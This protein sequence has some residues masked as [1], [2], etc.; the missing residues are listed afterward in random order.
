MRIDD[1]DPPREQPGAAASILTTLEACGFEWDGAVTYQ[2]A[3]HAR[4]EQALMALRH[5]GSTF[6]CGCTRKDFAGAVYPGTCR[7]GIPAGR[8]A[9]T[10]RLRVDGTVV[11]FRDRIGGWIERDP[12]REFGDFVLLRADGH[13]AYHLACVVDDAEAGITDIVRGADLLDSSAPQIV[14]QRLLGYPMPDYAHI[15][16]V[17]N[18]AGVKLSKQTFA[19]PVERAGVAAALFA[20]LEFLHQDP[21]AALRGAPPAELLAWAIPRWRIAALRPSARPGAPDSND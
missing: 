9:R 19:A 5:G 16:V 1:L 18:A 20:G 2:S 6:A 15:P 7:D 17:V 4:Y 11:R 12:A 13:Y 21:P 10:V 8:S 14:L 3:C